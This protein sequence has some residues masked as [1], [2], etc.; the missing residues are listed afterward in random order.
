MKA[1]IKVYFAKNPLITRETYETIKRRIRNEGLFIEATD[2]E[3]KLLINK[4]AIEI[5][6]AIEVKKG[7]K[8]GK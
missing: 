6:S 7:K 8:K 4:Q 2:S 5:V 1:L 3:G